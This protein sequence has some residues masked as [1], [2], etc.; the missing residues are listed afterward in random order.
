MVE[1]LMNK[2]TQSRARFSG[3]LPTEAMRRKLGQLSLAIIALVLAGCTTARLRVAS[4]DFG[5]SIWSDGQ[6]RAG[7]L[8]QDGAQSIPMNGGA[9]WT[10]GDTFVGKPQPGQQPRNPQ[11]T[12]CLWTTLAWLPAGKTN[13][14]PTLE[15]VADTN[16][17]AA[18]PL[19]LFPEEDQ[20][21]T[22][23]W[24]AHGIA[25]GARVYL[26]YAMIETTDGPGPWNFRGTG[27]GLA[28]ADV[29]VKQFTRLRPGGQSR[30]P[31]AP[32]Q[33]LRQRETLY[34]YEIS[35]K[36]KGLIL[37]RV[38]ARQIENP[39]EYEFFAGDKWSLHRSDAKVILREAYGQVS[40]AW[41]PGLHHF[42]MATSSDFSHPHEIQLRTSRRPDGP[43]SE[44]LRIAVPEMPGK[45][46]QLVYCT[47]LHP[48][49]SDAKSLRL[50]A[51]FCRILEGNWELSNPEWV[52][53]TLAPETSTNP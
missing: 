24:P 23:L 5:G 32:I 25:F 46:T 10:F 42:V 16:G 49:L 47:F 29:P 44:P 36:P 41:I 2:P 28:V 11:I 33:T 38:N 22:R 7:V 39:A 35:K 21:H 19:A 17:T 1:I 45:K 12:G 40:I 26:Y 53:I 13:L 31:V 48:E 27:A 15:Y 50:V 52:T 30:F 43:W 9:L 14:P 34:L 6:R 18:C 4:T 3:L 51:T 8:F 20:K 37:A